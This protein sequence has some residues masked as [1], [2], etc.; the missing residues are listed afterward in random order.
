MRLT[1]TCAVRWLVLAVAWGIAGCKDGGTKPIP[2]PFEVVAIDGWNDVVVDTRTGLMWARD[3]N[4]IALVTSINTDGYGLT[5]YEASVFMSSINQQAF[6]GYTNWRR[7]TT[8]EFIAFLGEG[9]SSAPFPG[10]FRNVVTQHPYWS[11]TN[12]EQCSPGVG[13]YQA[14]DRVSAEHGFVLTTLSGS[15]GYLWPV[16]TP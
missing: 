13:C 15:Q 16:R 5:N 1:N 3:A 4:L 9:V 8:N 12:H 2:N 14:Y 7:P 6:A 10:P 11:S